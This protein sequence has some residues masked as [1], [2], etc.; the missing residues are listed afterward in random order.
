MTR[1]IVW[2]AVPL[3]HAFYLRLRERG[4]VGEAIVRVLEQVLAEPPAPL[5]DAPHDG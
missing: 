1:P 5:P 4:D 2:T 3:P